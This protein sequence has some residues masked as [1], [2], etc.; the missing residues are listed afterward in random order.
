MVC[1]QTK[2]EKERSIQATY[3][4]DDI[5]LRLYVPVLKLYALHLTVHLLSTIFFKKECYHV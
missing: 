2:S 3:I 1:A 4:T 5:F